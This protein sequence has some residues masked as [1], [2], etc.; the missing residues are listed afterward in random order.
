MPARNLVRTRGG[1]V[2]HLST[3]RYAKSK[4]AVPWVWADTVG[5]N[6]SVRA[7]MAVHGVEECWTCRPLSDPNV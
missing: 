5:L 4:S 1:K 7:A 2:V 6:A 3:C